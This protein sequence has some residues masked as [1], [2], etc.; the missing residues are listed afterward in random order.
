MNRIYLL[1]LLF[2]WISCTTNLPEFT[3][4]LCITHVGIVDGEQGLVENRTVVI[5]DGKIVYIGDDAP[6]STK[7]ESQVVDA[8]EKFM[9]PGLWDAHVHFSY[10]EELA[11]KM[12]VRI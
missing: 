9:I 3:N 12:L 7:G 11:P 6:I 2:C 10:I 5:K 4:V 8:A 1:S